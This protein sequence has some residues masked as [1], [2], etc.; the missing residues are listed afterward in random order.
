MNI[1]GGDLIVKHYKNLKKYLSKYPD[2]N[3]LIHLVLGVGM[4]IL[5]TYPLV[6]SHPV[7]W[8]LLL[9]ALGVIGHIWAATRK[10]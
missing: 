2:V 8:G 6:G 3:G 1:Q 4:G 5:I 9:I 10:V 7:R